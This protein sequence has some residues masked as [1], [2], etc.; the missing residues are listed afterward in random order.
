MRFRN[1]SLSFCIDFM[2]HKCLELLLPPSHEEQI[3]Q[4]QVDCK[5]NE[6]QDITARHGQKSCERIFD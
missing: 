6:G 5:V 4:A 3:K 2:Y 1:K